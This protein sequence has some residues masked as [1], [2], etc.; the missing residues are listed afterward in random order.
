MQP[1]LPKTW[2]SLMVSKIVFPQ[3]MLSKRSQTLKMRLKIFPKI[4]PYRWLRIAKT[5]FKVPHQEKVSKQSKILK[6]KIKSFRR[7]PPM[8]III[9]LPPSLKTH[10]KRTKCNH[11]HQQRHQKQTDFP[12]FLKKIPKTQMK[13]ISTIALRRKSSTLKSNLA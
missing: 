10:K 5:L 7:G 2:V 11:N 4:I 6:L 12:Q 13:I 1:L 3:K 8:K 9:I